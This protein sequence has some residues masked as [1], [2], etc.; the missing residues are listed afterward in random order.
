M[1]SLHEDPKYENIKISRLLTALNAAVEIQKRKVVVGPYDSVGIMLY[2]T[3]RAHSRIASLSPVTTWPQTRRNETGL[4]SEIKK[5][6][7]V[8][9]PLSVINA[10]KILDLKRLIDGL[11]FSFSLSSVISHSMSQRRVKILIS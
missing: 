6:T 9:Q 3:V 2:N 10:P 5:G 7:Y 1:L 4:G 11:L 8:Y